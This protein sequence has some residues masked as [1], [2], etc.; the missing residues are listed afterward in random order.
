MAP[1]KAGMLR[2]RNQESK[3]QPR[4][5]RCKDLGGQRV[6]KNLLGMT[7]REN[8]SNLKLTRERKKK[9]SIRQVTR[10]GQRR[11]AKLPDFGC[12]KPILFSLKTKSSL[13]ANKQKS[14]G[15]GENL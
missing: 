13:R 1:G 11:E 14:C 10:S 4:T 12:K 7:T 2:G 6:G 5:G 15:E 9:L 3:Q 8:K